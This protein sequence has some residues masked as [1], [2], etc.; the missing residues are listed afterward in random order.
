ME[1]TKKVEVDI[2]I[3][4]AGL[5]GTSLALVLERNGLNVA[6][7]DKSTHPR[8]AL[9]ESLLKPTVLWLKALSK[10]FNAPELGDLA[11]FQRI[12]EKVGPTSG[13][14]K[15]F[16]FIRHEEGQ[17][18]AKDRWWL[19]S[20]VDYD[21]EVCES[22]L[23][24]QDIDAYLFHACAAECQ[25][26][27]TGSD[28]RDLN[29]DDSKVTLSVNSTEISGEFIVDCTGHGS[30]LANKYGSRDEKCTFKTDSE[31]IFTHF[32]DVAAFETCSSEKEPALPWS[33]GTLHH[34]ID[35]GWIWVIPFDNHSD[36]VNN[37]VS[38]G[39]TF[40][41]D[42]KPSKELKPEALWDLLLKKYPLLKSQFGAAKPVRPWIRT[43]KLQYSSSTAIGERYCLV[44]AA[45]GNIDALF[46]RGMLN[47]FQSVYLL[48]EL[49]IESKYSSNYSQEHFSPINTLLRDLLLVNDLLTYGCETAFRSSPLTDWWLSCWR[50]VEH[51]SISLAKSILQSLDCENSGARPPDKDTVLRGVAIDDCGEV[52]R[53]L[54]SGASIM[55]SYRIGSFSEDRAVS[56][57]IAL[58]SSFKHLGFD[59]DQYRHH[60]R[61]YGFYKDAHAV[62]RAE[63][64]FV[65]GVGKLDKTMGLNG[66][67]KS[68][69]IIGCVV[70]WASIEAAKL[71]RSRTKGG[72]HSVT[73]AQR[74]LEEK[75]T[76]TAEMIFDDRDR[77]NMCLEQIENIRGF[78]Y[79]QSYG[80]P[81]LSTNKSLPNFFA[82]FNESKLRV[83]WGPGSSSGEPC[84]SIEIC[85]G[86]TKSEVTHTF[87]IDFDE[88]AWQHSS[89]RLSLHV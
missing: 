61:S 10:R 5:A 58:S 22:H 23:F 18:R 63:Q 86:E 84:T 81:R 87:Q 55:D 69:P 56:E 3:V 53:L 65:E 52:K 31:S 38:V 71:K 12:T 35:E 37:I 7:I 14:K 80:D 26:T 9:G 76:K 57:L 68:Q 28:I 20:P 13:V 88:A 46:S 34:L 66:A 70:R 83:N 30:I 79:T 39:V 33:H 44:G 64:L 16:G 73:L 24:R 75:L 77:L 8:F 1:I 29:I 2:I 15:C 27:V 49:L 89:Q 85:L 36:A 59:F 60:L 54:V 62:L 25:I 51:R 6:L 43:N 50:V 19:N 47:T 11:D 41:A 48:A 17:L 45:Y 74:K 4:G 32:V 67:L 40:T 42:H 21:N 82:A 78:T 72:P